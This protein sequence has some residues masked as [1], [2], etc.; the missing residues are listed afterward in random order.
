MKSISHF[1]NFS[2]LNKT[3]VF[4]VPISQ[5]HIPIILNQYQI[6]PQ[7]NTKRKKQKHW[8]GHVFELRGGGGNTKTKTIRTPTLKDNAAQCLTFFYRSEGKAEATLT[9][10]GESG[11][12][13]GHCLRVWLFIF[14]YWYMLMLSFILL[15]FWGIWYTLAGRMTLLFIVALFIFG[16]SF[17]FST[18]CGCFFISCFTWC[19]CFAF[20]SQRA[21][22]SHVNRSSSWIWWCWRLHQVIFVWQ[23]INIVISCWYSFRSL[24]FV[25]WAVLYMWRRDNRLLKTKGDILLRRDTE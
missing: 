11:C 22:K 13:L 24:L 2:W 8:P 10:K 9:G 7:I 25:V 23:Y 14:F 4:K 6:H 5:C 1:I 19:E 20:S 21:R 3:C 12:S 18:H 17:F 15:W 16:I